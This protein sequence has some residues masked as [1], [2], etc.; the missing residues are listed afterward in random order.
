LNIDASRVGLWVCSAHGPLALSTLT[1]H[2]QRFRAGVLS[3]V[4]TLAIEGTAV[5]DAANQWGFAAFEPG[6]SVEGLP[7]TVPLLIVRAG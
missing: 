5:A 7:R 1:R 2:P 6:R 3:N 4:Y